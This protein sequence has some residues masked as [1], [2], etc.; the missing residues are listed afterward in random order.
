MFLLKQKLLRR[1]LRILLLSFDIV[2]FSNK[3]FYIYHAY[4]YLQKNI[5]SIKQKWI[6]ILN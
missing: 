5:D 4:L 3:T 2:H 1:F 6:K